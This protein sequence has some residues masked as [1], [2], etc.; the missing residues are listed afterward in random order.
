M[1]ALRLLPPFA[2]LLA[3]VPPYLLDVRVRGGDDLMSF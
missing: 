2:G 3:V 1:T